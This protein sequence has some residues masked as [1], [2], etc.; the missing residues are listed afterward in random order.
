MK[1]A[2]I[3]VPLIMLATACGSQTGSTSTVTQTA[4][5]KTITVDNT[6]SL[7]LS[8]CR[9]AMETLLGT[10]GLGLDAAQAY[11]NGQLPKGT[12]AVNKITHRLHV[13]KPLADLCR[14]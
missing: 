2:M 10:T 6:N 8:A 5:A 7:Q 4:P 12:V 1:R 3:V 13:V 11:L 9:R 14:G